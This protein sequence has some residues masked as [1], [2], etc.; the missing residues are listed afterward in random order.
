MKVVFVDTYYP[1]FLAEHYRRAPADGSYAEQQRRLLDEC[2]GVSDY[3]SRH[4]RALGVEAEDYIANAVPLQLRWAREQGMALGKLGAFVPARWLGSAE[5]GKLADASRVLGPI[6]IEQVR[7]SR[8]DVLYFHDLS[9][10]PPDAVRELKRHVKLLVGQI[11]CPLPPDEQLAPYD[12][13]L[14]SFP[15][16]V[17]RF[18]ER[19]LQSEY[20][21]IG[22]EPSVRARV[23]EPA[24]KWV[25]TF[26]GGISPSHHRGTALL[27]SVAETGLVDFFGY[28]KDTLRVGSP[29]TARHHGERWG[30]DMYRAL[31]ESRVTLNRHI[32]VA[33]RYANNMR[34]YEATG[35]GAMLLTDAKENLGELFEVGREVVA[36]DS[37]E[38][39][40]EMVRYYAEHDDER[41]RI[42]KAGQ[43]RTLRDH[44]YELRMK[45]LVE[46][47]RRA[48]ERS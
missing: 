41:E 34:L 8:P 40:V 24:R 25:C 12:L 7:R 38:E 29:I 46:I 27:T 32:D 11:A 18:R 1:A 22:F 47:L 28:G 6:L 43:A 14:T 4:L 35:M 15:H 33:E 37:A 21:R 3:Y 44:T 19:G 45:E 31:A 5:A 9:V 23:G 16:F 10:L 20:F 30:L 26:V 39:A 17:S 2:F 48:L 13:M 42:A 36:Y